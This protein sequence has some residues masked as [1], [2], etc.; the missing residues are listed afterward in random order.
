MLKNLIGEIR[1]M[2]KLKIMPNFSAL[3]RQYGI[4]RHTIRK[5]YDV[6]GIP[7]HKSRKKRKC[8]GKQLR[9]DIF[10]PIAKFL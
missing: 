3:S 5:Y 9:V 2:K 6:D 8:M 7:L 1:I 4:D 10:I